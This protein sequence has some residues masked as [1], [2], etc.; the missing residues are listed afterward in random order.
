MKL[1]AIIL[2]FSIN[3]YG[4][5][6]YDYIRDDYLRDHWKQGSLMVVA[7]ACDGTMDALRFHYSDVKST[8]P[9]LNDQFWNPSLSWTNKYKNNDVNQGESFY[10]SSRSLVCLT[11][12]WHALKAVRNV[13][14]TVALTINIS[15]IG[16]KNI[17]CYAVDI[18]YYTLCRYVGFYTTY[19]LIF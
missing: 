4:G 14:I 17:W 18:I 7:G 19:D 1:T 5:S 11:D 13:S 12:G 16:D 6:V 9:S 3:L 10:L 2:L 8:V 15:D